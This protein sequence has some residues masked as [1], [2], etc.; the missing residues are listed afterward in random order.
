MAQPNVDPSL[1]LQLVG[2][3]G[4]I[5]QQVFDL[6]VGRIRSGAFPTGFRLPPTRELSRHLGVHRNTLV[7]AYEALEDAGFVTSTVGRGTFVAAPPADAPPPPRQP[8]R[9]G[10]PWAQLTS[11]LCDAEPLLRLDR[12]RTRASGDAINCMRLQ[13][14]ADLLPDELIA[15]CLEHVLRSHGA[16]ALGYVAREGLLRLRT[17]IADDLARQGV[18]ATAEDLLITTGSQQALDLV[19]RALIEPGDTFLVEESTYT[20]A[21]NILTAAGAQLVTVPSDDEGPD[22]EALARVARPGVKGLY[23]MPGCNN[24]TG[25]RISAARRAALVEW[26]QRHGIPLIEDDYASDLHM[27]D[28]P[29]PAAMRAL[30]GDVIYLGTFSKKLIP[31]LRIGFVLCP[32]ALL[33]RLLPIKHTMDLGTSLLLQHT[34][35]EFLER[36]YLRAHLG[37]TVPEYRRRLAAFDGALRAALPST[38]T[39]RTPQSGVVLWLPLPDQLPSDAVFEEAQ[40]R[41]VLVSPGT[42]SAAKARPAHGLRLTFCAE[43]AERLVIG[44]RRLGEAIRALSGGTAHHPPDYAPIG[45]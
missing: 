33:P 4:P 39:W 30:D 11:R 21:I 35:A 25:T 17:A 44:A 18:P 27:T 20:G 36:G 13:P 3:S 28:S 14:S 34:L 12:L 7:R 37:R 9:P 15:R 26:S 29:P 23:L 19:A 31:A 32:R 24:P 6:I 38:L 2:T 16:R 40:Q 8:A 43:P 42:L 22:L 10:L 1:G 45:A 5:Y 41:G